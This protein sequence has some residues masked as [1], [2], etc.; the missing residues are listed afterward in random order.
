M[1]SISLV[2]PAYNEAENIAGGV[3]SARGDIGL[4]V[5][6]WTDLESIQGDEISV[7]IFQGAKSV[8][9]VGTSKGKGFQGVVKRHGFSGGDKTH[10]CKSHRVPGSIG[11]CATPSRVWV[12]NNASS[13]D[14][15]AR[16]CS[17]C[18]QQS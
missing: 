8:D 17:I 16:A 15:A 18:S 3:N 5:C 11:Q 6:Y 12:S 7:E 13:I 9:V 2:L 14:P 1:P 4:T 10:G